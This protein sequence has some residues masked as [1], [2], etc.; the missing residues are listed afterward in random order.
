MSRR[1]SSAPPALRLLNRLTGSSRARRRSSR[2]SYRSI[3]VAGPSQ[4]LRSST[5]PS[6]LRKHRAPIG[7]T[8][9]LVLLGA[10]NL[11]V[12]YYRHDTSVPALLEL[13]SAGRRASLGT[14]TRLVGPPGTPPVPM[15]SVRRIGASP[16]LP[17]YPRVIDIPLKAGDTLSGVLRSHAI[18]GP[19]YDE[20]QGRLRSLLDPGG[21]GAGQSFTLYYDL[22][23]RLAAL[24]YRLTDSSAFHLERVATGSTERFVSSRQEQP[25]TQK[26]ASLTI[27]IERDGELVSAL[28]R[29]G[30]QPALAARLGEIYA[31]ET[32]V[33][34]DTQAGDRFR[35]VFEKVLLGGSFYR[36]GRLLAA[37]Y[38]PAPRPAGASRSG[39]PDRPLRAFLSPSASSSL[40]STGAAP[41]AASHYFTESGDSLARTLCKA[42][43]L[44]GKAPGG[45]SAPAAARPV[46]RSERGR[47][48]LE[49]PAP[50]GTPVVAAG[51][52]KVTAILRG[53]GP[54]GPGSATLVLSHPGGLET[55][56]QNLGRLARG[57]VEGQPVRLRQII[58]YVGQPGRPSSAAAGEPAG[59][60]PRAHLYFA[61]R[62]A[63]KP[64][65]LGK[66]KGPR[67]AA[68]STSQRPAF[69]EQVADLMERLAQAQ[70][71][72]PAPTRVA[73]N[74]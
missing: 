74:R 55:T 38:Q 57:L 8:A 12:L 4:R 13:A 17:D 15:R 45:L 53:R 9:F 54:T 11:Y 6:L 10:V 73:A 65:D 60:P 30:E 58:G 48:G 42:P 56:Y 67:E 51:A 5:K 1:R 59:R 27:S 28:L 31:C 16:A 40:T 19:L 50:P 66:W 63:G 29:A 70:P 46:V 36:Y 69:S 39:R 21:L 24:D 34:T 3:Y 22:D 68:L 33:Y 61:L 41:G 14:H 47:L 2:R 64:V 71:A 62:A 52:G 25:R 43:L 32:S 49:Y 35:L 18:N 44:Y 37:E 72:Q 20:L 7:L 26:V 23:D